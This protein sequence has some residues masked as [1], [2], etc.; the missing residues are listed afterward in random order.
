MGKRR[1][2]QRIKFDKDGNK[3]LPE[4]VIGNERLASAAGTLDEEGFVVCTEHGKAPSAY[5]RHSRPIMLYKCCRRCIEEHCARVAAAIDL[6]VNR[7]LADGSIIVGAE[8]M[9]D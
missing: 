2:M 5:V 1:K 4:V 6:Q 3:I 8:W 9:D 7:K